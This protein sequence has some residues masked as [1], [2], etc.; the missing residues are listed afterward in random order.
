M[1]A[2][3]YMS[4]FSNLD[5]ENLRTALNIFAPSTVQVCASIAGRY[6]VRSNS[7]CKHLVIRS[8][9]KQQQT[10]KQCFFHVYNKKSDRN[11][12]WHCLYLYLMVKYAEYRTHHSTAKNDKKSLLINYFLSMLSLFDVIAFNVIIHVFTSL[13][14]LQLQLYYIN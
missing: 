11:S 7:R 6:A 10:I 12:D 5:L 9:F 14:S 8:R 13:C 2:M 4:V 3:C 1:T